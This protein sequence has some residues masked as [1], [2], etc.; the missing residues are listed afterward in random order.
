MNNAK[1]DQL[2]QHQHKIILITC[3]IPILLSLAG[4][5]PSYSDLEE[6]DYTLQSRDEW[7]AYLLEEQGLDGELVANYF[8]E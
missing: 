5:D 1:K 7:E 8:N 3:L 6:V 2:D 4:R